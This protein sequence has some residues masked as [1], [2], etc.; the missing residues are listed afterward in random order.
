MVA[1]FVSNGESRSTHDI[2]DDWRWTPLWMAESRFQQPHAAVHA[3]QA[4]LDH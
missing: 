1:V 3:L 2:E 4:G